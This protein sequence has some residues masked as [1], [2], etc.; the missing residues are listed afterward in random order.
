[1]PTEIIVTLWGNG[2]LASLAKKPAL[3]DWGT[4]PSSAIG[5]LV[6]KYPHEFGITVTDQSTVIS[7]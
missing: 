6:E 2:F 4:S 7:E 3:A 5:R 1:M